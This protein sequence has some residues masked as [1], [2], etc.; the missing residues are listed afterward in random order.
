G[1]YFNDRVVEVIDILLAT[2]E[3][4]EPIAVQR[5]AAADGG[6]SASALYVY[7]DPSLEARPAGQKILL[8]IGRDNAGKLMAKLREIRGE[9]AGGPTA[10]R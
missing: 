3:I 1:K 10:R 2:P 9:I 8:R 6:A 4:S 5:F 7:K